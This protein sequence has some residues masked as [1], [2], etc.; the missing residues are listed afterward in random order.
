M[1][2]YHCKGLDKTNFWS[3]SIK[4]GE[5]GAAPL[6][7]PVEI[8]SEERAD[9]VLQFV[10]FDHLQFQFLR[11]LC[12]EIPQQISSEQ[13][14][15]SSAFLEQS[16]LSKLWVAEESVPRVSSAKIDL[17]RKVQEQY[18]QQDWEHHCW[19]VPKAKGGLV[20]L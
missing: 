3:K 7:P 14:V 19:Q 8:W 20:I 4:I 6:R 1:D 12:L 17:L 10:P 9:L 5:G 11:S 16:L 2:K 15:L 18:P 13:K